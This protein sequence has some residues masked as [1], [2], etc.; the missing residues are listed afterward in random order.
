MS[1]STATYYQQWRLANPEKYKATQRARAERDRSDP[2]AIRRKRCQALRRNYGITADQ[3]DS[4][5]AEQGGCAVCKAAP[6]G[7]PFHVD[8]C[9][10]TG[11]VRG[12]L[13]P[14]CN[15]FLGKID[16]IH[17]TLERLNDYCRKA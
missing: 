16:N 5:L 3:Y 8:H 4:M 9:H 6:A 15:W 17:G 13:C 10:T 12:I 2:A 7:K 1:G 11:K 14:A